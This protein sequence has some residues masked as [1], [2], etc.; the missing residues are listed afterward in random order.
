M[1][2][3]IPISVLTLEVS[4][5]FMPSTMNRTVPWHGVL[6]AILLFARLRLLLFLLLLLLF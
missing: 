3:P 5:A 4:L 6:L 1:A 2:K